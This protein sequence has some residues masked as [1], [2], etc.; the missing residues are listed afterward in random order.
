[1]YRKDV[2]VLRELAK[3][4]MEAASWDIQNER[5][6]LW[7]DFNS[8]KTR[9]VPIFI[10]ETMFAWRELSS[11]EDREFQCDNHFFLLCEKWLRYNLLHASLGDDFILEPWITV[12]P[13]YN[14]NAP[15][16][17]KTY[18][19]NIREEHIKDTLARRYPNPPVKSIYN[20]SEMVTGFIEID[21][22]KQK[23]RWT[24]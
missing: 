12:Y 14:K 13:E 5:R 2:L 8:M 18:G 3:K 20:L 24:C 16:D 11:D 23:K 10:L 4:T 17:W 9:R 6:E 19:F 21:E 7:S 22:E 1:M 15:P